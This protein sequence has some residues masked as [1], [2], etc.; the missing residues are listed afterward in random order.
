MSH[1][2][3]RDAGARRFRLLGYSDDQ[4]KAEVHIREFDRPA[5]LRRAVA[6]LATWWA[7][8][9][10][11]V[12]I[13]VAHFVLVPGFAGFGL[14]VFFQR[15]RTDVIVVAAHGT[16]PDCGEEQDLDL[17]GRWE[18]GQSVSCRSCHRS[19]RLSAG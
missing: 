12:F 18:E 17:S 19:L 9:L 8:A 11:C 2:V 4:G 3:S 6:G 1:P 13:P 15:L 14:F 10:G 7:V 5:R 16:C